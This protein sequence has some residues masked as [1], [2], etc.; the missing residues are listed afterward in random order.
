MPRLVDKYVFKEITVPFVLGLAI[1]T[2]TALLS[3][4]IKLVD[5]LITHG[6]GFS[7]VF[8]FVASIIPSFLI[9]TIPIAFLVAV[10]IAFT[11]LSADSE[12][13][14][15]K[16]SGLSLFTLMRP[17]AAMAAAVCAV[18]LVTTLYFF[19]WGNLTFKRLLFDAARARLTSSLE[20]KTFYDKFKGAVL[21]AD[22]ILP[23]TGEMEGIFISD[24]SSGKDTSV[25]FARKGVFVPSQKELS[26]YL[27]LHDGTVHKRTE[28]DDAY[29]IADF[30]AYLL[31]LSM[32]GSDPANFFNKTNRELYPSEFLD[33][34]RRIEAKGEDPAP[35]VIDFHKRFALPASVFVFS[36]LGLPL[37]LQKIRSAKFTGISITLGV[38]LVY[39][40]LSTAFEALGN[41]GVINPVLSVWAS[42]IIC[43]MAGAFIFYKTA[44]DKPIGALLLL[45]RIGRLGASRIYRGA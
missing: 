14:A 35:F 7:F 33:R 38:V 13:T 24:S 12:I 17:V 29:H 19:P 34:I 28:K 21:Y 43:G 27:E 1:L 4:V 45:N 39:Y 3:K 11:R 40:V 9:Y 18:S 26:L 30:S 16:A 8:W 37:G 32:P 41:N 22:H 6:V 23:Q 5:M 42:D 44:K 15:M 2:A 25:F 10:L 31:E 36:L 20:E